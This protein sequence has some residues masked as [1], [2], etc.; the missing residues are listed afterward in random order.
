MTNYAVKIFTSFYI[1]RN[2]PAVCG[3]AFCNGAKKNMLFKYKPDGDYL[4][5]LFELLSDQ[6]R[7]L[8]GTMNEC[9]IHLEVH[10]HHKNKNFKAA[11][12]KVIKAADTARCYETS[13]RDNIIKHTLTRKDYHKPNCY[14]KMAELVRVLIEV[15][16]PTYRVTLT[17]CG[18]SRSPGQLAVYTACQGAWNDL[19]VVPS[20][21]VADTPSDTVVI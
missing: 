20:A 6:I 21:E 4:N 10:I 7:P 9:R 16:D 8:K 2:Q 11:L 12:D 5:G 13:V 18:D 19:R 15:N 14:E 1:E 17:T 3:A